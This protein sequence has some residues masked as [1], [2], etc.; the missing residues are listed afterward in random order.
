MAGLD[1]EQQRRQYAELAELPGAIARQQGN[2]AG[3]MAD[4]AARLEAV[5][6]LPY[7]AHAPME[8]LNCLAD[9]RPDGCDIWVGTQFQTGDHQA[10]VQITGLKPEQVKLHTTLIGGGL[11]PPGRLRQP[12]RQG[13]SAGFKSSG[14]SGQSD[15]DPRR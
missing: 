9:V 12:F 7:L 13:S 8:P 10:A 6:E 5:Y 15:L 2:V 1:S 11:R 3:A 14:D 4:A